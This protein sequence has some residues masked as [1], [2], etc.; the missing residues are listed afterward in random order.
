MLINRNIEELILKCSKEFVCI[1][2]YG[3]RQVGKSTVLDMVFEDKYSKVTLDDTANKNLAKRNPKLF[4]ENYG[5]P[6]IIDEIQK[7]PELLSEIKIIIDK[8]KAYWNKNNLPYELMYIL[9]GSSQFEL[10]EAVSESLAGRTAILNMSSLSY[11]EINNNKAHGAFDPNIEVLKIKEKTYKPIYRTRKTIF[12]DIFKGGMP[13]YIARNSDRDVFFS[14]YINTYLEKDIRKLVS[15]DNETTFLRFLEYIALRT[16]CQIDYADIANAIGI[17]SRTVKK[18]ISILRT[19]GIIVL[20]EP[21]MKNV[22]DRII[23]ASKLYFMDTGLCAYLC[24][25][26]TAEMLEKGI[27]SGAFYET[28]VVSEII[29]SYYNAN[30]LFS[31]PIYYYR[32]RDQKEVDLIVENIEGIYPIEIKKGVNPVSY[33]K[34]FSFLNKYNKPILKGLVIDSCEKIMPINETIYYCPISLIGL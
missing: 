2:L 17:D 20:L 21:Y 9:T 24:K 15:A 27:M 28:Y 4:L 23:K 11:N 8:Q 3:A 33:K 19:S 32:D 1:T 6:L 26:P 18:W 22:S 12:E 14:S 16:A 30:S 25:W 29:K 5:W 34:N 10:Q 13:E 7:A 31:L